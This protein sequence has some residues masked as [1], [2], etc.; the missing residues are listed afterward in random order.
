MNQR[1]N[2]AT[3]TV[4]EWSRR[5]VIA[6]AECQMATGDPGSHNCVRVWLVLCVDQSSYFFGYMSVISY[7]FFIMLGSIG[8][9]R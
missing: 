4:H 2:S 3:H 6:C 9:Y 8:F 5:T 7:A 1:L